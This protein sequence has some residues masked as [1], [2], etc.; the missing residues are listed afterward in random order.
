VGD[1]APS[2]RKL[3]GGGYA[4]LAQLLLASV[5]GLLL[6][7]QR[8]TAA[9]GILLAVHLGVIFSFFVTAPYSMFVHGVYRSAALLRNALE[10]NE[11]LSS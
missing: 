10:S 7:A 3:R 2:V 4:L 8:D 11:S 6:L 5:T 1:P 9:M